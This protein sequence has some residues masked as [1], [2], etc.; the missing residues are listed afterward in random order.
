[1]KRT[2]PLKLPDSAGANL[3]WALLETSGGILLTLIIYVVLGNFLDAR[4]FGQVA[5]AMIVANMVMPFSMLGMG[6]ALI[7]HR[8]FSGELLSGVFWISILLAAVWGLGIWLLA[9][10]LGTAFGD[11][12]LVTITRFLAVLPVFE[13]VFRTMAVAHRRELNLRPLAVRRIVGLVVAG[14]ISIGLAVE[15]S[16]AAALAI[17][18]LVNSAV[19]ALTLLWKTP[20]PLKLR[21][22]FREIRGLFPYGWNAA[23]LH[24][25]EVF[26]K[27]LLAI[28]V[29]GVFGV[30]MLGLYA[31]AD[32][33]ASLFQEAAGRA[34]HQFTFP[35]FSRLQTEN[36]GLQS[37]FTR[38]FEWVAAFSL[39][40]YGG[41][42]WMATDLLGYLFGD[43]WLGAG[44]LV[45]ILIIGYQ[46]ETFL[47][48]VHALGRAK[49]CPQVILGNRI[50]AA[51][52][53]CA[54]FLVSHSYG[55][56]AL[57]LNVSLAWLLVCPLLY[58]RVMTIIGWSISWRRYRIWVPAVSL[59]VMLGF[60]GGVAGFHFSGLLH[61]L[62]TGVS[63]LIGYS[64][65][66]FI[67]HPEPLKVLF[68]WRWSPVSG[69]TD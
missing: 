66:W 61:L 29:G 13:A 28:L 65:T 58:R 14:S 40:A 35:L 38:S 41:L 42:A 20:V 21:C 55:L 53:V 63:M 67:L 46:G 26:R 11:E 6:E 16:G 32:R 30:E 18:H 57:F 34:V 52:L 5:I 23:G 47:T 48:L 7:R 36:L 51:G 1:M 24:L 39:L 25:I 68:F 60:G 4:N 22:S 37:I 2:A 33:M 69:P 59:L 15:G 17:F 56:Y 3:S 10:V 12:D 27:R 54:I 62:A 50:F 43:R 44:W 64:M 45:P 31:F 9:P 19:G 8:R 49:G